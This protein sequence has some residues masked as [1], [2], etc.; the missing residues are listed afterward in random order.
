[1]VYNNSSISVHKSID[2][3]QAMAASLSLTDPCVKSRQVNQYHKNRR[4]P[5]SSNHLKVSVCSRSR[6]AVVDLLILIAVI[7]AFGSL[8]YPYVKFIYIKAVA[9][10]GLVICVVKEEVFQNPVIYGSLGVS[11]LCVTMSA[12]GIVMCTSRKCG[13]PSCRGRWKAAEFDIQLE[14]EECLKNSNSVVKDHAKTG[15]FELPCNH[16]RE[17]EAELKKMAPPNGR[18][19]L[20]FRARCGCSVGR[21]EVP[22]PRKPRKIKK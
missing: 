20:V 5:N 3:S 7:C 19:V 9:I 17:L 21:M 12:W 10:A 13:N 8:L 18:A 16:H 4:V 1:M 22:G 11:I 2:Q 6:S 15:L 14:T